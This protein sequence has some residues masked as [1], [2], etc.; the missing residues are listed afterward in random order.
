VRVSGRT[1]PQAQVYGYGQIGIMFGKAPD[2]TL[3]G[4]GGSGSETATGASAF[5]FG[6]GGGVILSDQFNL[7]V[8]LCQ[9]N[10]EYTYTIIAGSTQKTGTGSQSTT[11]LLFTFGINF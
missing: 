6:L 2:I 5:A 8:R 11:C 4:P 9:A 10:P 1:S 7:G 3:S